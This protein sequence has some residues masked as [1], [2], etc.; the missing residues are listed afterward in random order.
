MVVLSVKAEK[1][2]ELKH[3][4]ARSGRGAG[5]RV[6]KRKPAIAI[7]DKPRNW[8]SKSVASKY[9]IM[10]MSSLKPLSKT[11]E[12]SVSCGLGRDTF[13]K[14]VRALYGT[15][16]KNLNRRMKSQKRFQ[17]LARELRNTEKEIAEPFRTDYLPSSGILAMNFGKN[18]SIPQKFVRQP[19]SMYTRKVVRNGKTVL[20]KRRKRSGLSTISL[21]L[22]G[23]FDR[24]V[25]SILFSDRVGSKS[26]SRRTL[27]KVARMWRKYRR[28][29]GKSAKLKR[30]RKTKFSNKEKQFINDGV[31][32]IKRVVPDDV[33]NISLC[34]VYATNDKRDR[35]IQRMLSYVGFNQVRKGKAYVKRVKSP[36]SRVALNIPFMNYNPPKRLQIAAHELAKNRAYDS[37]TGSIKLVHPQAPIVKA[38]RTNEIGFDDLEGTN[39]RVRFPKNE[40]EFLLTYGSGVILSRAGAKKLEYIYRSK[41]HPAFSLSKAGFKK[42]GTEVRRG[43]LVVDVGH[44]FRSSK[45]NVSHFTGK[46]NW[47]TK[48][49]RHSVGRSGVK[50]F[51]TRKYVIVRRAIPRVGDKIVSRTGIKGIVTDVIRDSKADMI[52]NPI[53]VWQE[54]T[55]NK[56]GEIESKGIGKGV[57]EKGLYGSQK[58]RGSLIKEIDKSDGK[59][60]AMLSHDDFAEDRT[61]IGFALSFT[62]L[63]GSMEK[64][65]VH[66][67]IDNYVSGRFLKDIFKFSH[68]DL[69]KQGDTY[70]F[71][72]DKHEPIADAF[73][74]IEEHH[75]KFNGKDYKYL[76]IPNTFDS[77]YFDSKRG[78]LKELFPGRELVGEFRRRI[79]A[80]NPS[81]TSE[82]VGKG[83][84][85][86]LIRERVEGYRNMKKR[87]KSYLSGKLGRP[88]Y[89][90]AVLLTAV[91]ADNREN[92]LVVDE[93]DAD[94]LDVKDGD[95]VTAFKEPVTSSRSVGTF[96]LRVDSTGK[97]KGCVGIHPLVAENMTTDFDG[98]QLCIFVPALSKR[99]EP[100]PS[101]PLDKF[102]KIPR[103]LDVRSLSK[104]AEFNND[105]DLAWYCQDWNEYMRRHDN[106]GIVKFGGMRKRVVLLAPK[107][108]K[109][110]PMV[111]YSVGISSANKYLDVEQIM[112]RRT[113][114]KRIESE[115]IVKAMERSVDMEKKSSGKSSV[116]PLL[117]VQKEKKVV[118]PES[119][120]GRK[121]FPKRYW[122][123][124]LIVAQYKSAEPSRRIV[125]RVR[126]VRREEA[127]ERARPE[128]PDI[129]ELEHKIEELRNRGE[130]MEARALELEVLS[131]K[132][133][134]KK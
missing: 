103:T 87:V 61:S 23:R 112:K 97:Y 17:K 68:L 89:E 123:D 96:R 20:V 120:V 74:R 47:M 114:A 119:L 81:M 62:F 32:T 121:L 65:G 109:R 91:A 31:E 5:K 1:R 48:P 93:I 49:K 9:R 126:V 14:N 131:I 88:D 21:T 29:K 85:A 108:F 36:F 92:E 7:V 113:P 63:A 19:P 100:K 46:I 53:E 77:Y 82:Q 69:V 107:I 101:M 25:G 66:S 94:V 15:T 2:R 10:V 16:W 51:F 110:K 129:G 99:F 60:F 45:R 105:E 64:I 12:A 26:T 40:R 76:Y 70:R 132:S 37:T 55:T 3:V 44:G 134:H 59:V 38:S 118:S 111:R 56:Y 115:R 106:A 117:K 35:G 79:R 41:K 128:E 18:H 30:L 8:S 84:E 39:L 71:V 124:A 6:V 42:N 133:K 67:L 95:V 34:P 83:A 90:K 80:K 50:E 54:D 73:G 98:D 86:E 127:E 72:Q 130:F 122:V 24:T 104:R 27:E 75:H 116:F 102:A 78:Q 57:K 43:E 58:R 33:K 11:E 4:P 28:T 13:D 125:P 22:P 52:I